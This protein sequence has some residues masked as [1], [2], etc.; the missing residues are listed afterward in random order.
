MLILNELS[1]FN[2]K[3]LVHRNTYIK[4]N[5]KVFIGKVLKVIKRPGN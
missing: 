2:F 4:T 3:F 5:R 1:I